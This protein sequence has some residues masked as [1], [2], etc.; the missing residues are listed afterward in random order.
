MQL[1]GHSQFHEE[2]G[3]RFD[4]NPKFWG[5]PVRSEKRDRCGRRKQ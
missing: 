1:L 2:I 5:I 4:A 3:L